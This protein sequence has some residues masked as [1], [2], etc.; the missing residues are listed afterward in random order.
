[1]GSGV[2]SLKKC[3]DIMPINVTVTNSGMITGIYNKN[4]SIYISS[5]KITFQG[6]SFSLRLRS[7]KNLKIEWL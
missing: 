4:F 3:S 7:H 1:M 5:F 2:K 6:L